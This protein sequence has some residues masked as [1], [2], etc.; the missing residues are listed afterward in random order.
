MPKNKERFK[1]ARMKLSEA[2]ARVKDAL[3][4][5]YEAGESEAIAAFLLADIT[6]MNQGKEMDNR[7]R[8]LDQQ[9]LQ[10]L[11]D[12]I[13]RLRKNEPVQYITGK[14]WFYD[15]EVFVDRHVLIPRPETE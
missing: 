4:G 8:E 1:F 3:L 5:I 7:S 6:G 9:E 11:D 13:E 12:G 14:C 2:K 15:M 10:K